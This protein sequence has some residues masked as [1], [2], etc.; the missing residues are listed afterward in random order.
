MSDDQQEHE[1]DRTHLNN[2]FAS[3]LD[4]MLQAKAA[5]PRDVYRLA[6]L[7]EGML[8]SL[9]KPDALATIRGELRALIYDISEASSG[10]D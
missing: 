2:P 4:R 6:V 1:S 9:D 10:S 8:D 5:R 7:M 3:A